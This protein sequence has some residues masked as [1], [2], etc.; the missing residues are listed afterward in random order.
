MTAT[1]AS[2]A[3]PRI[4]GIGASAG[5]LG[6]LAEFLAFVPADSGLAYIVVQHLDPTHKAM[7]AELLQRSTAM[8]VREAAEGLRIEPD[9]VYVIP[10]NRELTVKAGALRLAEPAQ[11]RGM[12]LPV[13]VLF[14][15]LAREQGERA[16]G[17]VL[18]GMG[19]DGTMGLQ[20]IKSCGGLT[21]AQQPDSAQ[22]D[23]MPKSAIAAASV[24]IVALA[25]E[26]PEHI[27]RVCQERQAASL[28][29][30]GTSES[31]SLALETI[32]GLLR[33]RS[34]HDMSQYK[35][36][37]LRR[38]VQRRM[39]VHNL[40]SMVAYEDFVRQNPQ[41]LDLLFKE[42]LIGVTSFFR[43][44]AVWQDLKE[45]VMPA[46][47]QGC[48]E[49]ARLRAWVVGCSTGEEAYSLAMVFSEVADALGGAG[50]RSMQIFASDLSADAIA[51]A[52]KGCYPA[53]IAAELGPERLARF[54]SAQQG[55][56]YLIDKQIREMVLFAQHD[57]ILDPPFTRLDLLSCRNLMIYFNASLQRRLIPLF[58]YSL[59]PG[60][61]LVLGGSET[62]GNAQMLFTALNP[63]SRIYWR[64]GS[65][66]NGQTVHFPIPQRLPS[67]R[68]AQEQ[69][70]SQPAA[71]V[72]NLQALAEQALLH[73]FSPPAVLVNEQGDVVY[74]N[75]SIGR[76][77]EPASG[78]ANWNIHVMAR[79]SFRIQ[80]AAALRQAHDEKKPV[81][82]RGLHLDD[83]VRR[84]L[85]VIIK[86]LL[87][88][89]ALIGLLMVVFREHPATPAVKRRRKPAGEA[90]DAGDPALIEELQRWKDEVQALRQEMGA[91]AEELQAANEELQS[92][93]EELQS[94]NEE[95]TT[96]KE[97]SQSM[98][99]ELQTLNGE[100]QSKLDDLALAQSDMQNLLNSTDIATLFLDSALN[101]RRYTD[102]IT[103]IIHLR[104][105]DIG[106]P[107]TDLASTLIYPELNEDAKETLRMLT[108]TEK[109]IATSDGH[110]YMVRIKPYRTVANVIQGVVITLIDITAAKQLESRLRSK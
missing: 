5:G 18:S 107:L 14:S 108:F 37:T 48:A 29:P 98:N 55:G 59:R 49:G 25:A 53:R 80:M 27:L 61:A 83:G 103:R 91:S 73:E 52:R 102:Q 90:S 33:M 96:S 84:S 92:T 94:A 24:D 65:P 72:A 39:S 99:E 20:A 10:P 26:L 85:D 86:P 35:P 74:I 81:E 67:G 97:E 78:K 21:L 62:V 58:S 66:A 19:S 104:E 4:V 34:R 105:S 71:Q 76:Y 68:P 23:S 89:K 16:I 36:S 11:P 46:L 95:L 3:E 54:F 60:G 63:K 101:V 88:P 57:V 8:P 106:R 44:P 45:T 70:L 69:N 30:E 75:G 13:N 22:F 79:P 51:V 28:P 100:L 40:P 15:S 93:N 43:D 42:M 32:L 82:L 9:V 41:E 50:A 47:L 87:E 110:W 7:L 77:L 12:R 17:V 1:L 109:Q 56:A 31:D 38:R 6:A 64:S 2:Y